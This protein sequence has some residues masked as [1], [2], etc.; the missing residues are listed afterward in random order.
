[1]TPLKQS[2]QGSFQ[3]PRSPAVRYEYSLKNKNYSALKKEHV[4]SAPRDRTIYCC[5]QKEGPNDTLEA[6]STGCELQGILS[7]VGVNPVVT[8]SVTG[9]T[10][11]GVGTV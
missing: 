10:H 11:P 7:L 5:L 9:G 6:S 1:M 8:H 4:L 3:T 2:F